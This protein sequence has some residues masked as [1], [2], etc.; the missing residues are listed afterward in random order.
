MYL[1]LKDFAIRIIQSFFVNVALSQ[2]MW[3][4]FQIS[5]NIFHFCILNLPK[6]FCP[7]HGND[8]ILIAFGILQVRKYCNYEMHSSLSLDEYRRM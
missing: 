1:H 2:K 3:K 8:E 6:L 7:L 5:Q 4:D